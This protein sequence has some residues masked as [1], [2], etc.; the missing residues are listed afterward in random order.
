MLIHH[1]WQACI[2]GMRIT[3]SLLVGLVAK[4]K[5]ISYIIQEYPDLEAEDV[6]QAL[7]YAARLT[8]ENNT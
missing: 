6:Q 1:G 7:E 8:R 2:R 3:V 4:G 5:S